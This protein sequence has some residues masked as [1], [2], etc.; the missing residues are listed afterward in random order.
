MQ[1]PFETPKNLVIPADS[2]RLDS[3]IVGSPTIVLSDLVPTVAITPS[4]PVSGVTTYGDMDYSNQTTNHTEWASY[5]FREIDQSEG[6]MTRLKFSAPADPVAAATPYQII[7]TSDAAPW[8]AVL[9][10]FLV[11]KN[12]RLPV[13]V[14]TASGV[15]DVPRFTVLYGLRAACAGHCKLSIKKYASS[16]PFN[17]TQ[18]TYTFPQPTNIVWDLPGTSGEIERCLHED[19]RVRVAQS[20]TNWQDTPKYAYYPETNMTDWEPI[21]WDVCDQ[22]DILFTREQFTLYPPPITESSIYVR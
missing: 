17:L 2:R 21:T 15:I 18:S 10:M 22:V 20:G 12:S 13:Q 7:D 11:V 14:K 16:I 3:P 8:P 4:W 6:N 1:R 19:V 9:E 5:V